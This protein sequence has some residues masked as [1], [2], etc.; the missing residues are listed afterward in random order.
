MDT[1]NRR[2]IWGLFITLFLWSC[3]G[4]STE[5][6]P[7]SDGM[8]IESEDKVRFRFMGVASFLIERGEDAILTDPFYSNHS[9][10]KV[11]LGKI[12]IDT[13]QVHHVL[14]IAKLKNVK[15]V[16]V[17]HNHY[18][19]SMALPYITGKLDSKA[20]ICGSKTLQN[21][22]AASN[23][24]EEMVSMNELMG[25]IEQ[26]GEWVYS[27]DNS[28]RIMAFFA[29][30]PPHIGNINL[31]P[32][33]ILTPR[34]TPPRKAKHY[35][36]G[37]TFSFLIDFLDETSKPEF[38]IFIATSTT[39]PPDAMF[40]KTL[41]TEKSIDVALLSAARV[42]LFEE[43]PQKFIEELKPANIILCHWE[44]FFRKKDKPLQIVSKT[45][46]HSYFDQLA[47]SDIETP[48]ILPNLKSEHE[49]EVL[50]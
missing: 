42:Q 5:G 44:N 45:D 12:G 25:N 29:T 18:D 11:G 21:T 47:E 2:I 10:L 7:L 24:Q 49:F 20:K 30:H 15:M 1:R 9:F 38:R 32:K 3:A 31:Y 48:I 46:L 23:I 4:K 50:P 8:Q 36:E 17:G 41:L 28:I 33:K 43:H 27:Y 14:P 26:T 39:S 22:F 40:P 35:Q 19:H 34:I 6:L 37:Q 16:T 13:S